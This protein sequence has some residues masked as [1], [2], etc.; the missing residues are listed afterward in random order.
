MMKDFP[1]LASE[2]WRGALHVDG[3]M[4]QELSELALVMSVLHAC[5]R[6]QEV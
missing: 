1:R 6:F 4:G 2:N 5:A 3:L